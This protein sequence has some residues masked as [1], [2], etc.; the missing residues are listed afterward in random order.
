[1]GK[2]QTEVREIR[3]VFEPELTQAYFSVQATGDC[4]IGVQGWH[5][6]T[7]PA[8]VSASDILARAGDGQESY[9]LWPLDAPP[10]RG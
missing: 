7:F 10:E 1:M 6:K 4:P 3:F 8:S 5:H 2:C 9:L